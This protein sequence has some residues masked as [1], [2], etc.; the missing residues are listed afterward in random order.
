MG[1]ILNTTLFVVFMMVKNIKNILNTSN[2]KILNVSTIKIC[3]YKSFVTV[4]DINANNKK[5]VPTHK[6]FYF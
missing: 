6:P 4:F 2:L 1:I 3:Q 5:L